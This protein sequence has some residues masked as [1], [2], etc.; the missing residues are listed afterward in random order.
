MILNRYK[1]VFFSISI[2]LFGCG[3]IDQANLDAEIQE[4]A[5]EYIK[6]SE[7][8]FDQSKMSLGKIENIEFPSL[9]SIN[10]MIEVPPQQ[11]AV[12]MATMGGYIK[13]TPLLEGDYVNKGD[14]LVT[15]E[16]PKFIELQQEYLEVNEQL[17]FF[18]AEYDRQ[19]KLK[20]E[21]ITSE[22]SFL[23]AESEYKTLVAKHT[24]LEK[25]LDLLNISPIEVKAG[26]ISSIST[27]Y[28]PITGSITKI[29][30]SIGSYVSPADAILEIIDSD[31]MH[32]ELFVFEK[33]IMKIKKG[34]AI[35]FRIPESSKE[36][37]KAEVYL[38]GTSILANRTIQVHGHV[39]DESEHNF[40]S[41]MFVEAEIITGSD[42][43]LIGIEKFAA[44]KDEAIVNNDETSYVLVLAKKENGIYFF[45]RSTVEVI[46]NYSGYSAIKTK[47]NLDTNSQFLINGAFSLL[48]E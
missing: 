17:S 41:G 34:Q 43:S 39:E 7:A 1:I 14:A 23:K 47:V 25:Q 36:T 5:N 26:K 42:S 38:V 33:D 16:N 40:L 4:K 9:I 11:R 2:A 15:L 35:N 20:E 13:T 24:G 30:I 44:L 8:Q 28:A 46:K 6:V 10:G 18:K 37:Y 3:K 21:N 45:K 27:I 48:G 29:N 32:L 22:K 31:H 19:V 12:V